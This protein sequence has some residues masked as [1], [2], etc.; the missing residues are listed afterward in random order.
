MARIF[1]TGAQGLL[2]SSLGP[3]LRDSGHDLVSHARNS[4][5]QLRV[6]LTDT[7]QVSAALTEARPEVIINLAALTSV[8]ACEKNPQHAYQEN[9]KIVENLAR[10]IRE[11]G[12]DCHLVQLSTDQV[13]DG[14]GPH[15]EDD[16]TLSNYY[17][18]S[19][20]AGELVA[21]TVSSTI[22]R[23]N[24]FGASRCPGRV[25]LSD[26]LV[27]SAKNDTAITV[28]ED[29]QF[30]PLSLQRLVTLIGLVVERRCQGTF[31]LGSKDGMSKADFAFALAEVLNLS[32]SHVTVGT[33]EAVKLATYRPKDMRM[34]S[35]CFEKTFGVELPTLK[36]EI[37]SMKVAY[38]NQAG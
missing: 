33:S 11:N 9:V 8:D 3:G 25:S 4:P 7:A 16:I 14:R 6:D 19:K 37:Q 38:A 32:T 12:Q 31:N 10:W 36:Q 27:E 5:S 2:G 18:F 24:F 21:A 1:V 34:N 20:F 23:T 26:W 15:K 28:F 29:V 22:L 30:S 17:G 13:Y 35:T